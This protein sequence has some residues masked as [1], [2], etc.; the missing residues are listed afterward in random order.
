MLG[1]NTPT[2]IDALRPKSPVRGGSSNVNN[3]SQSNMGAGLPQLPNLPQNL[4]TMA[5]PMAAQSMGM[6]SQSPR[7]GTG[8]FGGGG[9]NYTRSNRDSNQNRMMGPPRL[10][11][12]NM[13]GMG[14]GSTPAM[15]GMGVG[16]VGMNG[17]LGGMGMGGMNGGMG[18]GTGMGMMPWQ[19]M[20][21]MGGMNV[22]GGM[23]GMGV[24]GM[25]NMQGHSMGMNVGGPPPRFNQSMGLSG[26][27]SLGTTGLNVNSGGFGGGQQH[28][29][30]GGMGMG[31]WPDGQFSG[32]GMGVGDGG[33]WDGDG[34]V[35]G[36]G[37]VNVPGID[38][39]GMGMGQMNT[40]GNMSNM[41]MGGMGMGMNQWG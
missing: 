6:N 41:G 11:M 34:G 19:D 14:M 26:G 9:N 29:Q 20:S 16:G 7:L 8:G 35:M 10:G 37:G 2:E 17:D 5:V 39:N 18:M 15:G 33:G 30:I 13:N 28:S 32:M 24:G 27:V 38:L 3:S 12:V 31:G 1:T 40:M 22:S 25:G 4:S 21:G 23:G 36:M